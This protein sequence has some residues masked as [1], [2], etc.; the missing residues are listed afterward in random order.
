M[1]SPIIILIEEQLG[2]VEILYASVVIWLNFSILYN[3]S[4]V[5][6]IRL[7]DMNRPPLHTKFFN[8]YEYLF[9]DENKNI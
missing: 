5:I 4:V 3:K 8:K 2:G 9:A 7:A 6:I 1:A